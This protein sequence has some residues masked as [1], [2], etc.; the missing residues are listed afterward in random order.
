MTLSEDDVDPLYA[1]ILDYFVEGRG[2]GGPWGKATPTEVYRAL[3]DRGTLE[4]LGDP[5]RQTVQNRIQKLA[6]AGHLENKYDSGSY[7]F[8]SDP[9]EADDE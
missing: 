3:E 1:A 4:E 5:V 8:V 6:L 9:R 7:E 2:D